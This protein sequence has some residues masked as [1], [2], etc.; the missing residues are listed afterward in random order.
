MGVWQGE[1]AE[2][3]GG[4]SLAVSAN[5]T[6]DGL[7]P[8]RSHDA[9]CHATRRLSPMTHFFVCSPRLSQETEEYKRLGPAGEARG[10]MNK[11]M[12]GMDSLDPAQARALQQAAIVSLARV[13]RARYK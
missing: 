8:R 2:C 5:K 10:L 13:S 11:H 6:H 7:L 12:S 4:P 9:P 3:M 1:D